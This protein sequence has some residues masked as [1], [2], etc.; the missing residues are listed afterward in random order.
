MRVDLPASV[1]EPLDPQHE[2]RGAR[3]L[4]EAE[5]RRERRK[6]KRKPKVFVLDLRKES[7]KGRNTATT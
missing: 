4:R 7:D 3:V 1:I 2:E 5:A 6:A